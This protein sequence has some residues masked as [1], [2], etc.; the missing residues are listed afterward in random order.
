MSIDDDNGAGTP[1][2]PSDSVAF[3]DDAP[4]ARCGDELPAGHDPTDLCPICAIVDKALREQAD[5]EKVL[6]K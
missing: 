4:C 6:T 2:V 3:D 5:A 1:M